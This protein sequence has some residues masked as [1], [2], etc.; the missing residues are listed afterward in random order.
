MTAVCGMPKVG[1]LDGRGF[2]ILNL[3]LVCQRIDLFERKSKIRSSESVAE[4]NFYL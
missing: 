1:L 3:G 2:L 4:Q